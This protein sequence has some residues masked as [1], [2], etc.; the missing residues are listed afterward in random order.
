MTSSATVGLLGLGVD[1][2]LAPHVARELAVRCADLGYGSLWC[3]DVP[4][5]SGLETLAHFAAGAPPL[6]LGVGVLPLDQ[7]PP[8]QTRRRSSGSGSTS[9]KLWVGIGSGRLRPQLAPVREAVAELRDLLPA[10]RIM[11]GSDAP[12]DVPARRNDRRRCAAQLDVAV[13]CGGG[14]RLGPRGG[15]RGRT[16]PSRDRPLHPRRSGRRRHA[17]AARRR[18]S[19]PPAGAS[20]LRGDERAAGCCR[21]VR[22][23]RMRMS[24]RRWRRTVGRSTCRSCE[25][26]PMT[27][28]VRSSMSLRRRRRSRA[29][30][31]SRGYVSTSSTVF[32]A[33]RAAS[34]GAVS[35]RACA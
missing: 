1:A 7:H 22:F 10:A 18:G 24:S 5:A 33:I 11:I 2:G 26:S 28:S 20:A 32:R 19:V 12:A 25:C 3:N 17:A 34:A 15:T 21:R 6:D 31:I 35:L 23:L 29:G 8:G 4:K 16:R 27:T 13:T 9:S 14:A 30:F